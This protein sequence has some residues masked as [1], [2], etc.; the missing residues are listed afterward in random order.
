MTVGQ[1]FLS[2]EFQCSTKGVWGLCFLIFLNSATTNKTQKN[3]P[4]N[5]AHCSVERSVSVH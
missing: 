2:V 5:K 3:P 4:W 1:P